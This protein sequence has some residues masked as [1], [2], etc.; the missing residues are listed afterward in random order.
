M[1]L[2]FNSRVSF[3]Y[4]SGFQSLHA[5]FHADETGFYFANAGEVTAFNHDGTRNTNADVSLQ[6][7]P[8]SERVW[9]FTKDTASQWV[10]LTRQTGTGTIGRVHFY[11]QTGSAVR[12][13]DVPDVITGINNVATRFRAPKVIAESEGNYYVRVVRAVVGNMRFIKFDESG[14]I[15]DDDLVVDNA[16]ITTL[17]D[18]ASDGSNVLYILHQGQNRVY[19]VDTA[20]FREI[21]SQRTDLDSRN[22]GPFGLSIASDTAYVADT[23]G[24]IYNYE[25]AVVVKSTEARNEGRVGLPLLQLWAVAQRRQQ[26][27][28]RRDENERRRRGLP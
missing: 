6:N 13:F 14:Q 25:G 21:S 27:F 26:S 19:A 15:Q 23:G 17:S 11:S 3:V 12:V 18:A 9:G 2:N 5:N 1:A 7:A 16:D 24:F 10:V 8:K 20:N 4:P 28:N 22:T